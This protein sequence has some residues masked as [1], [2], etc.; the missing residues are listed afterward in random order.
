M[1][2]KVRQPFLDNNKWSPD[3][4]DIKHMKKHVTM[5]ALMNS[6]KWKLFHSDF[7]LEIKKM[8]KAG[9]LPPTIKIACMFQTGKTIS[10]CV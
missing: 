2:N 7:P 9:E 4:D 5:Q 10:G 1:H 6:G 8:V 3:E